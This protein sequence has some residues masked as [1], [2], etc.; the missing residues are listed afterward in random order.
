[1][2]QYELHRTQCSNGV[3]LEGHYERC[4]YERC[5]LK[6]M[7]YWVLREWRLITLMDGYPY[8]GEW[9]RIHGNKKKDIGVLK[10]VRD[11]PPTVAPAVEYKRKK[12]TV[13]IEV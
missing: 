12:I 8:A 11:N 6:G 1:M 13:P 2:P 9:H 7:P 3:T 10:L 4:Y 5:Y